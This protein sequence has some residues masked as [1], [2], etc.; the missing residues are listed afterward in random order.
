MNRIQVKA[1]H[2]VQ[3]SPGLTILMAENE[4]VTACFLEF[5]LQKSGDRVIRSN[6]G[7]H[8]KRLMSVM[9]HPEAVVIDTILLDT[10]RAGLL[11]YLRIQ[12]PCQATPA[13]ML[14]T[15]AESLDP[16]Q[17]ALLGVDDH[18]LKPVSPTRL[19]TRWNRL[20]K[21]PRRKQTRVA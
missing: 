4:E 16:G 15:N 14:T 18:I 3:G 20:V 1:Y 7:E 21:Q 11:A 17:A 19:A 12:A 13:A 9:N 10:T 6:N 8:A 5:V 2:P